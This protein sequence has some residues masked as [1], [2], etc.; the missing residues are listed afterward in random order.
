MAG[1]GGV[2]GGGKSASKPRKRRN[3][4]RSG[5]PNGL[6]VFAVDIE[7]NVQITEK[8]HIACL[9]VAVRVRSEDKQPVLIQVP[10]EPVQLARLANQCAGAI[11]SQVHTGVSIIT[12]RAPQAAPVITKVKPEPMGALAPIV[13][14]E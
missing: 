2:R 14:E 8:T 12:H 6:S 5:G 13:D 3:T 9:S 1:V 10:L 7:P 4:V 11:L